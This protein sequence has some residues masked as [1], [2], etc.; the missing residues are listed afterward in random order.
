MVTMAMADAVFEG[1]CRGVVP[2]TVLYDER[3]TL[4]RK[5]KS[6]LAGQAS[7]VPIEFLAA[8]STEAQCRFPAL[9]HRRSITVLTVVGGDGAVYEGERAWL[10]CA[11]ALPSWQ[12]IAERLAT[13]SGLHFTRIAS[14]AIDRY[15]H[16]RI[17]A[18]YRVD[19][20]QC[21]IAAPT[22]P[23]FSHAR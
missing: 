14:R 1:Q 7:L 11:W 4:C 17:V 16:Q 20:E 13:R 2:L 5:L 3:C 18:T 6:W 12:P 19:C 22:T 9:D 15:R 21:R 8:G 10:V 23:P